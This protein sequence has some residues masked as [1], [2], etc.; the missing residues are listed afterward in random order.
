MSPYVKGGVMFRARSIGAG[1]LAVLYSLLAG[2]AAAYAQTDRGTITGQVTDP[3]TA[4][5][6]G[7]SVRAVHV[8][9]NFE[10]QVTTSTEGS[11]TIPQLPV[12]AYVLIVRAT[13][14]Q[15]TTLD[16]ILVTAGAAVGGGAPPRPGRLP[17]PRPRLC[18]APRHPNRC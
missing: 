4:V 13:N 10:R 5:I 12:G 1:S 6:S 9:T 7:A 16:N 3:S 8:A 18:D 15:T 11:Y 2:A 14:F 17:G